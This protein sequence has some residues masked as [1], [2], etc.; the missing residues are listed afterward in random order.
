[1]TSGHFFFAAIRGLQIFFSGH[2]PCKFFF[3]VIFFGRGGEGGVKIGS[4][5][6]ICRLC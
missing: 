3:I 5:L 6:G 1:M 4:I 2:V